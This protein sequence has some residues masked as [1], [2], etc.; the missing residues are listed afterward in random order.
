MEAP[1]VDATPLKIAEGRPEPP[2]C[3]SAVVRVRDRDY[4]IDFWPDREW[5]RLASP[6]RPDACRA[7]TDDGWF[8][9]APLPHAGRS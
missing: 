5:E 8:A 1:E 7:H 2:R 4:R 3:S 9:V 6:D